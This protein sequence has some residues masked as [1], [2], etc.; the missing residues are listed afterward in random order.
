MLS[1]FAIASFGLPGT[2][3]FVGEFL[4]LVG[5]SYGGMLKVLLAMGGIV[6]AAAYMLWMLQRVA[7]G[8]PSTPAGAMLPDLGAREIL[9]LAPLVIVVFAVGLFPAAITEAL[10]LTVNGLVEQATAV[11]EATGSISD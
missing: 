3:N 9:T 2:A 1:I 11:A 10:E 7:L 4:V 8:K 5:T 6:L